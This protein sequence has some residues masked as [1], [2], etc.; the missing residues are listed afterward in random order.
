MPQSFKAKS[1]I[2]CSHQVLPHCHH[3]IAWRKK[4]KEEAII[5]YVCV[6]SLQWA[7]PWVADGQHCYPH[8][9]NTAKDSHC[10][11]IFVCRTAKASR[12]RQKSHSEAEKPRRA[13]WPSGQPTRLAQS[14]WGAFRG[15]EKGAWQSSA[16]TEEKPVLWG[17]ALQ[18]WKRAIS[19][20]LA[21]IVN[22]Q[23][24][25]RGSQ[26]NSSC[27]GFSDLRL[28]FGG[29]CPQRGDWRETS[30]FLLLLLTGALNSPAALAY[31]MKTAILTRN[32]THAV[33]SKALITSKPQKC[34]RTF[35]GGNVSGFLATSQ[36]RGNLKVFMLQSIFQLV[37]KA[38]RVSSSQLY[39][40][41]PGDTVWKF[42]CSLSDLLVSQVRIKYDGP[43]APIF[44]PKVRFFSSH[45]YSVKHSHRQRMQPLQY[46]TKSPLGLLQQ[47]WK[48]HELLPM[49]LLETKT[50]VVNKLFF[51]ILQSIRI[52]SVSFFTVKSITRRKA[53]QTWIY[54]VTVIDT[55]LVKDST[56][57]GSTK[58]PQN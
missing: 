17:A 36:K 7:A 10:R 32:S 13:F 25:P 16:G 9:A 40:T 19:V 47:M 54:R 30:E 38:H 4:E 50:K 43:V 21:T 44:V 29:C 26:V 28:S 41:T 34:I 2:S 5:P 3:F 24:Y 58:R 55:E 18:W 11:N 20:F 22:R 48:K 51:E 8:R 14:L 23:F 52:P 56:E 46:A 35:A 37:Q 39:S 49:Q 31:A 57:N 15:K 27:R 42:S 45:V 33:H 1:F 6:L 53:T 12:K